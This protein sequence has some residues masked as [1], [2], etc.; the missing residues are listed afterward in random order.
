MIDSNE[1]DTMQVNE[2]LRG[3]I[4][5][6]RTELGKVASER[7]ENLMLLRLSVQQTK[8]AQDIAQQYM[9]LLASSAAGACTERDGPVHHKH[10]HQ[11]SIAV[12]CTQTSV[13]EEN[14]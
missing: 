10:Q 9:E 6:L 13:V 7:D 4:V 12:G 11:P 14:S 8:E 1:L 3:T 5:N 2:C